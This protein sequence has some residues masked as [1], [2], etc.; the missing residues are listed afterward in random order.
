MIETTPEGY[1][2]LIG[3]DGSRTFMIDSD[4]LAESISYIR[5]RD[6]R[7]IGINS[8]SGY[9]R[10]EIEFLSEIAD[11]I[12]GITVLGDKFDTSVL[13]KLHKLKTLGF[14]DNGKSVIDLSN[15]PNLST[16]ACEYSPRLK[17]L[18]SCGE[19]KH[20]TLTGYKDK[21]KN[22]T[23]MPLLSSL[24]E[25]SL[26]KTN[27]DTLE[28]IGRF[29]L[30]K[31]VSLF[32]AGQLQQIDDVRALKNTLVSI[33][34]DQ[35][36]KIVSYEPLGELENLLRLVLFRCHAIESLH[37]IKRL[38]RLEFLS[39]VGTDVLDG[40]LSP[41]F[42]ITYVGFNDKSHYSHSFK[43]FSARG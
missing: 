14:T 42:G 10:S 34:F 27:I 1:K 25:L 41:A 12:E 3:S 11:F 20:L 43:D 8:Y 28:G 24:E 26:F 18:D 16:L 19:L 35:C 17:S 23:A 33:E 2:I 38:E 31:K 7:I 5:G 29:R 15:F 4:R 32:R 36:K 37:F 13:N 39:F 30:L 40:N 21:I 9:E 6:I 22:L